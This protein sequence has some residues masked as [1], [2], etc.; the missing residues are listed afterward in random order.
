MGLAPYA[1]VLRNGIDFLKENNKFIF[2]TYSKAI[3]PYDGFIFWIKRKEETVIVKSIEHT[4]EEMLQEGDTFRS[5]STL[6]LTSEEPLFDFSQNDL[7]TIKVIV[8]NNNRYVI[9]KS[10][11][12]TGESGIF[13][14]M[15]RIIE[16]PLESIL[17]DS[18]DD[19]RSR[20]IQLSSSIPLFILLASGV[21]D[22]VPV[23]YDLYPA[24]LVPFNK[25]PPYITVEIIKTT[26]LASGSQ[27]VIHHEKE[28]LLKLVQEEVK[29]VLYGFDNDAAFIFLKQLEKWSTI[30][31]YIGFMN[32]PCIEDE[33]HNQVEL[34]SVAQKK[35]IELVISY[36][37]SA[38]LLDELKEKMIST[39]LMEFNYNNE[40]KNVLRCQRE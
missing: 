27:T 16:K 12:N 40:V 4:A 13:H 28:Y 15:A 37:Q 1:G 25:K 20:K 19:F 14:Y 30:Y 17:L 36:Y 5:E 29:F 10:G 7:E 8:C 21:F 11:E 2:I 6:I 33:V 26:A 22:L 38:E 35:S 9:R 32:M 34:G 24:W 3:L 31:N 23:H 18:E 39:V